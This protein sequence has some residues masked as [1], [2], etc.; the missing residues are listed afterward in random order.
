[1]YYK[2]MVEKEPEFT[3]I[4]IMKKSLR[5]LRLIKADKDFNTYDETIAYL[6]RKYGG[7]NE[8]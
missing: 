6:Y 7:Q 8:D 3:T 4:R 5:L 1:M 2:W